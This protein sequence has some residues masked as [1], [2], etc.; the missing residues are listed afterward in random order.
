M[1][2]KIITES[3]ECFFFLP[4]SQQPYW[5]LGRLI[6]EVPRSR[7]DTPHSVGLLCTSDRPVL[8][9]SP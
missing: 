7:T 4:V 2:T 6:G 1:Q 8:E 5:G 9:T 3:H